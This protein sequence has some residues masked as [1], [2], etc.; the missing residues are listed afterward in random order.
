[1]KYEKVLN[2]IQSIFLS[3]DIKEYNS[4]FENFSSHL[5]LYPSC[6]IVGLGSGRM[7]FSLRSFI[8]RLSHM[9]FNSSMIGDTN[10]P[11]IDDKS[12]I[13]INSSS[14]ET[15]SNILYANQAKSRGALIFLVS[16]K[17]DSSIAKLSDYLLIYSQIP[18]S[19]LMKSV[20]EQFT[21][22]FFDIFSKNLQEKLKISTDFI[23]SNHSILE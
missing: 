1:M 15:M 22:I 12:I 5:L 19:Q 11:S 3:I 13:F 17:S 6:N 23:E 7:G 21:L 9:G 2:E 10:V 8:M 18:S 20:Y 14:G 4:F 16:S